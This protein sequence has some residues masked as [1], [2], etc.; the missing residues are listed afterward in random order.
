MKKRIMLVRK[1]I[2]KY[3]KYIKTLR[4]TGFKIEKEN[5]F[6]SSINNNDYMFYRGMSF[7]IILFSIIFIR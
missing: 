4:G 7:S 1:K 2:G 5:Q 3:S 6:K